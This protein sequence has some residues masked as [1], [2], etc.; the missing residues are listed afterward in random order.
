MVHLE[1]QKELAVRLFLSSGAQRTVESADAARLD[2]PFFIVTRRDANTG[3]V[4]TLLTLRA[5][6]V[7]AGEVV[8]GWNH[9]LRSRPRPD[10]LI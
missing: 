7:V 1:E 6:D 9:R 5:V 3:R 8:K 10:P 2:D 4:D